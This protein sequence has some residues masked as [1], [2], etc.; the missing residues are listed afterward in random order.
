MRRQVKWQLLLP[1]AVGQALETPSAPPG[2]TLEV[3]PL[4][5]SRALVRV[6]WK[7]PEIQGNHTCEIEIACR[8]PERR[9]LRVPVSAYVLAP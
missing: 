8:L 9:L 7:L 5:G 1:C 4:D 6:L 3:Q 2:V